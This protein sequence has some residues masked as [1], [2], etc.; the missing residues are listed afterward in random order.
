MA[1]KSLEN[2]CATR[3]QSIWRG[4]LV[5]KRLNIDQERQRNLRRSTNQSNTLGARIRH[6]LDVLDMPGVSISQIV[7]S[8]NELHTVTRLSPEC[9]ELFVRESAISGLF[10]FITSCNRSVPHMDLIKFSLDIF[11]NLAKYSKTVNQILQYNNSFQ[12][13]LNLLQAYHIT[14]S[15]I[16]MNVCVLLLLL[17]RH[18]CL[19]EEIELATEPDKINSKLTTI[20]TALEKRRQAV[21]LQP[22][23][24]NILKK[25]VYNL[26]PEWQLSKKSNLIEISDSL[27][28][29]EVLLAEMGM[30]PAPTAS[31]MKSSSKKFLAKKDTSQTS[32]LVKKPSTSARK[33]EYKNE[34][35]E[36][37][38]TILMNDHNISVS[39]VTI[40]SVSSFFNEEPHLNSTRNHV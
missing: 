23:K 5:R 13:L 36:Q 26:E 14:N 40:R 28:A 24:L 27:N 10:V 20:H 1:Q 35:E 37:S 7:T 22:R 16:F 34:L 39:N 4:Y 12:V 33:I 17:H 29:L 32:G 38:T 2:A 6:S 3:I 19:K 11:I 31:A 25:V 15:S 8:L 21:K 30:K 18:G 9:C